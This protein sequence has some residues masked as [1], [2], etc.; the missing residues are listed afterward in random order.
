M[1]DDDAKSSP[2]IAVHDR[3][4]VIRTLSLLM[5]RERPCFPRP[6]QEAIWI[7]S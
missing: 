6:S 1:E 2:I 4:L 3:I 7:L 5:D